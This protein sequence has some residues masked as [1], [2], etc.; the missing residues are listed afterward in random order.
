MIII[1]SKKKEKIKFKETIYLFCCKCEILIEV[2]ARELQECVKSRN[3][4]C[5]KFKYNLC[6]GPNLISKEFVSDY[7]KELEIIKKR[8]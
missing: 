1:G 8:F 2:Y 5:Y 4:D 7:E 3:K 6:K